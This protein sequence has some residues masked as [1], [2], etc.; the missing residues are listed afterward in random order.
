MLPLVGKVLVAN[1]RNKE[2]DV[3]VEEMKIIWVLA[4]LLSFRSNCRLVAS[5]PAKQSR[6]SFERKNLP[7]MGYTEVIDVEIVENVAAMEESSEKE[8]SLDDANPRDSLTILDNSVFEKMSTVS[9]T[10]PRDKKVVN[11]SHKAPSIGETTGGAYNILL[12]TV[13]STGPSSLHNNGRFRNIDDSDSTGAD[14]DSVS[15]NGSCCNG[16]CVCNSYEYIDI[17]R[18]N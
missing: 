15:N 1:E 4:K 7:P 10:K 12:E 16:K 6:S 2:F 14:C 18:V 8:E 9:K 13:E 11:D 17:S 3:D 5:D